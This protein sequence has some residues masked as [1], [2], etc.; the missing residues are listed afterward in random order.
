MA[1]SQTLRTLKLSLLADVS[2]FGSQLDKAG[3]GFKKFSKGVEQA[4]KFAN[5]AIGAIGAIG[6]S[7]VNAASDLDETSSA[8]EQVF[9]RRASAQLQ[10][11]ARDA[12]QALGQ[13]RQA[14]LEASQTF[15]IFGTAADRKSVV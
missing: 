13:S 4:S 3:S 14:A 1:A 15:G 6:T 7:A 8:V 12:A 11:F 10:A 9:G 2:N 5:V